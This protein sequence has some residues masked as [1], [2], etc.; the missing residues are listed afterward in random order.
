MAAAV[1]RSVALEY[2]AV[3]ARAGLAPG[4]VGPGAAG[5]ALRRWLRDPPAEAA[6]VDVILG[7]AAYCLAASHGG[8]L[9]V[10]RNRRRDAGAGEAER[11]RREVDRTAALAGNGTGPAARARGGRGRAAPSSASCSGPAAPPG[12]DGALE[13]A[14]LPVEA[15]ELAWLARG[16][17]DEPAR[18][19]RRARRRPDVR[20]ARPRLSS[21]WRRW[22]CASRSPRA[23]GS[24][25]R[26]AARRGRAWSRTRRE[27][28][29]AS[30][31][32]AGPAGAATAPTRLLS[33]RA[34]LTAE[35]PP[36]RV[37]A[38]LEALLP[39]DVRLMA[40]TLDYGERLDAGHAGSAARQPASY[41]LFLQRLQQSPLFADVRPG[42]ET[43]DGGVRAQVQAA[44]RGGRR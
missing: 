1:R 6:A 18:T 2:E 14:G 41:D 23:A 39:G 29:A 4:R 30:R 20:T 17:A 35:A 38:D 42:E 9:R 36:P 12:P 43:R 3:A 26:P 19:S 13:G 32:G 22:R 25:G 24:L 28:E 5:R 33:A 16:A 31:D 21:P 40:L 7:D 11:L 34:L 8:A 44:Y 27:T 37:L 10:L 15:A